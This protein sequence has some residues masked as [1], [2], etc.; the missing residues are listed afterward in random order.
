MEGVTMRPSTIPE[1]NIRQPVVAGSFYTA[2]A[3]VL[4]Q[5]IARYLKNVPA[6][7]APPQN[8]VGLIAPHAGYM[9]SGQVAAYAYK[10][11]EGRKYDAVVVLAPSH[12][13][14]F[15]GASVDDKEGYRTP[16]GVVRV[17]QDMA[18]E[19]KDQSPLLTHYPSAH[20]QEHSLE[21]QIPFLQVALEDFTL[22]PIVMGDQDLA[23]AENIARAI[24]DVIRK[25]SVLVV[26][27]SDLS[28]YHPYDEAKKLDQKVI[29]YIN[30]YDP[31]GLAADLSQH[32]T[33]AC[34][35]GPIITALLIGQHLG[36]DH[37]KVIHYANSGDVTG[38]HSGVVGYVAGII[39]RTNG[40]KAEEKKGRRKAG[41]N[42]GLTEDEKEQLHQIVRETIKSRLDGDPLP[43]F[44][45]DS[46]TLREPRGAFVSLHKEGMLRGCIG[47]I[48]ADR[49]LDET[50]K[51]MA[52]AAAFEDPR[53]PPLSRKEF[54][55]VD[56]EISVL[57]PFK[58]ITDVD[59][60][61]VGKHGLYMIKGFYSGI[62]LPQVAT[63]YG[64]DQSTF[65][66]H[67]CTKAGLPK[68]AWKEK[69]TEIYIFSADVF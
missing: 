41:I 49:P 58:K 44:K 27:S 39:Y 63:E 67:T 15:S 8:P 21:V 25:H 34:G 37:A 7:E 23:T 4:S 51:K 36:A 13:A 18:R 62:L 1:K 19:I 66:E 30:R 22:I 10:K 60:I 5:E 12:R 6:E 26:A 38:D 33:E 46:K 52:L 55:Q 29:D 64:W 54:N 65:L 9:Y 20:T 59:E 61:E 42:L 32:K 40:R 28:H 35:G 45:V 47:H 2:N 53:F 3:Q 57:T 24:A 56:I 43:D 68:N 14:Y 50:I 11:I 17:N 16:L 31:R 69:D 48:K